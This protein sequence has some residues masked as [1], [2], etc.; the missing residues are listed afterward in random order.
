MSNLE[1]L[2]K[3][4]AT[5]DAQIVEFNA[6]VSEAAALFANG[7]ADQ[8]ALDQALAERDA[9]VARRKA[10]HDALQGLAAQSAQHEVAELEKAR[11]AANKRAL[12]LLPEIE[13]TAAHI[14]EYVNEIVAAILRL[15]ELN[16]QFR[17]EAYEAGVKDYGTRHY[18]TDLRPVSALLADRLSR[19][20]IAAKLDFVSV[21][22]TQ[23]M[24]PGTDLTSMVKG[25][26]AKLAAVLAKVA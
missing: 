26:T 20:G 12:A 8:A 23:H 6:I 5:L 21:S 17:S 10:M 19:S 22:G 16:A 4:I 15:D 7:K 2:T 11:K 9:T 3:T 18:T 1:A 13:V 14:D 25:R 24:E